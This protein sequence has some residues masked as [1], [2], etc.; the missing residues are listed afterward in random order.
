MP[1]GFTTWNGAA[2]W[3]NEQF[4]EPGTVFNFAELLRR[5]KRA[6]HPDM[7]GNTDLFRRVTLAETTLREAGRL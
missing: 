3:L 6:T 4:G 5:A 7:G 1:A 2:E